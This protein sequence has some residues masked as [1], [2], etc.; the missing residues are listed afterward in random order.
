MSVC[1]CMCTPAHCCFDMGKTTGREM[2]QGGG[3]GGEQKAVRMEE[4]QTS[5]TS[6]MSQIIIIF[7]S[8]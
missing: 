4:E 8:V 2:R 3:N 7:G 1:L 5:N 6:C